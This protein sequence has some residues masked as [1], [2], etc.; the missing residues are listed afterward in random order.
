LE[1]RE[2]AG[3]GGHGDH[4]KRKKYIDVFLEFSFSK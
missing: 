3:V 1:V 2:K 4:Y